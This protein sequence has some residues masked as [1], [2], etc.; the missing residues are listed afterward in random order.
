MVPCHFLPCKKFGKRTTALLDTPAKHPSPGGR[1]SLNISTPHLI[2]STNILP[3]TWRS[4][5]TRSM[6][7]T[8][9]GAAESFSHSAEPPVAA[10]DAVELHS[11]QA[12]CMNPYINDR[13]SSPDDTLESQSK[14][15]IADDAY[16]TESADTQ[17]HLALL[18]PPS[19]PRVGLRRRATIR[20]A[21]SAVL[22]TRTA[23]NRLA[24]Y[25]KLSHGSRPHASS[26]PS[27]ARSDRRRG[28]RSERDSTV[29]SRSKENEGFDGL[30]SRDCQ[31]SAWTRPV[32]RRRRPHTTAMTADTPGN[33]QSMSKAASGNNSEN[34]VLCDIT[35][36]FEGTS[37]NAGT[38]HRVP[39]LPSQRLRR[40]PRIPS[41]LL[42]TDENASQTPKVSDGR[43]SGHHDGIHIRS[44]HG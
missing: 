18:S 23:E 2:S 5:S 1:C 36:A 20:V 15:P 17:L 44:L 30:Y 6:R 31:T 34:R 37:T 41:E 32:T 24:A 28:E 19:I 21:G 9:V 14:P 22:K 12:A 10:S 27:A 35:N 43:W 29:P 38:M 25:N 13:P 7:K 42:K 39:R 4:K 16:T 40:R 8:V 11:P 26:T 33:C 3:D